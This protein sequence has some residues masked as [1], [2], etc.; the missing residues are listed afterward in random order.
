MKRSIQTPVFCV[1]VLL[2]FA[3]PVLANKTAVYTFSTPLNKQSAASVSVTISNNGVSDTTTVSIPGNV[4]VTEKRNLI[5]TALRAK[6]YTTTRVGTDCLWINE[7][8][9][10]AVATFDP[11]QT[12]ESKDIVEYSHPVPHS[13]NGNVSM[14]NADGYYIPYDEDGNIAIFTGGFVTDLGEYWV[15]LSA[16]ELGFDTTPAYIC[17]RLWEALEPE[18]PNY[19][20]IVLYAGTSLEFH[21]DP[22]TT[23]D[24]GGVI[25][26]TTSPSAGFRG[27]VE[28]TGESGGC[29]GDINGDG[30]VD[31]ADLAELLAAYGTFE[32]HPG[33][34]PAADIDQD[35]W[36][37]LADLAALLGVYG[38]ECP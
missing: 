23:I 29:P 22:T 25:F 26:G 21:F 34:N 36:I 15:E 9:E 32:G 11:G 3:A 5:D 33:Y 8:A 24:R 6:G 20:V 4:D 16:D 13:V 14:D 2:V 37:G 35:G 7:L 28:L 19:G 12:G 17:Q 31:L 10:T 38:S 1:A 30:V 27:S 18:A